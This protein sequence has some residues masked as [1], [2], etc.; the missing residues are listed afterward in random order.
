M[1]AENEYK[2][3]RLGCAGV[4]IAKITSG[5]RSEWLLEDGGR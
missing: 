4:T 2:E 3:C 5:Q 1:K